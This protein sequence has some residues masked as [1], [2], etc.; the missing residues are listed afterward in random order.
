MTSGHNAFKGSTYQKVIWL[1]P[2]QLTEVS[3]C[4]RSIGFKAEVTVVVCWRQVAALPRVRRIKEKFLLD[5]HH[6][7]S[8][9]CLV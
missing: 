9:L 2:E 6:I 1:D 5:N 8:T 3:E 4:Y 7:T